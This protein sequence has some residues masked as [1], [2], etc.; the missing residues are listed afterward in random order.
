LFGVAADFLIGREQRFFEQKDSKASKVFGSVFKGSALG[1]T[2]Y[3][4]AGSLKT[5]PWIPF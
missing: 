5:S 2:G 3:D 4:A 1:I